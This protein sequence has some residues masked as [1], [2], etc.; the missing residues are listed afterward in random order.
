MWLVMVIIV[1]LIVLDLFII[2]YLGLRRWKK[3]I[4]ELTGKLYRAR[5]GFKPKQF[6]LSDLEGLPKPVQ[7]YFSAVLK[8]G[9]PLISFAE[10]EHVG[11]FNMS[12][13]EES[14]KPFKSNQKVTTQRPGFLWNAKVQLIPWVNIHI[15]DAYIAGV[16]YLTAELIGLFNMMC[17]PHTV[18]LDEGELIRYL[19]EAV[20]YPTALLPGQG[21]D[22]LPVDENSARAMLTDGDITI[23]LIF[24]FNDEG[25]V[26][27]IYCDGRY[28]DVL[29]KM[30]RTPWEAR[31]WQYEEL[32]NIKVPVYGEVAWAKPCRRKEYFHGRL[33]RIRY[34]Y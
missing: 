18:Q 23:N 6:S 10:F 17:Q 5:K 14:W 4:Y 24:S 7:R 19:A 8:E 29:G 25:L 15:Y 26:E 20:W 3:E 16:G 12:D 1:V 21:V 33:R 30:T 28:K 22:W 2:S 34:E 11:M 13:H 32:D 9:Q 31:V 27:T